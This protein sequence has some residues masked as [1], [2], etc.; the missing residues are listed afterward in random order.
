M[1]SAQTLPAVAPYQPT[2]FGDVGK[3][4]NPDGSFYVYFDTA[5]WG[6]KLDGFIEQMHQLLVAAVPDEEQKQMAE[7]V[8]QL[9]GGFVKESGLHA[10]RGVGMSSVPESDTFY[11]NRVAVVHGLPGPPEGLYWDMFVDGNAP[12]AFLDSVP[13]DAVLAIYSPFKPKA[14][15]DW[16]K[17]AVVDTGYEPVAASLNQWVMGMRGMGVDVDQW[18]ESVGPRMGLMVTV[19]RDQTALLPLP[20]GGKLEIPQMAAAV[21]FEVKDDT[22]FQFVDAMLQPMPNVIRLDDADLRIR[23]VQVPVPVPINV[24]PTIARMGPYLIL[25]S[26]DEIVKAMDACRHGEKAVLRTDEE[27]QALSKDLPTEGIGFS[28]LSRRFGGTIAAIMQG[29]LAADPN[30]Q[31]VSALMSALQ[32]QQSSYGVSLRMP[33][34]VVGISRTDFEL[35]ETLVAQ[36]AVMPVALMAGVT[37]P[38]LAKARGRAREVGDMSNLKQIG[39]GLF[40]FADDHNGQFPQDLGETWPYV[41]NGQVFVSPQGRT[42]A[43]QNAEQVRAGQCDYLYFVGGKKQVDI[44]NP[45]QTPA[46]CTKPG[47][48]PRGVNVL[49]CDGHVTRSMVVD[50]GLKALIDAAQPPQQ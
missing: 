41:G 36:A 17:Q 8:F 22:I 48:L 26:N 42:A 20:T 34:G 11:Y 7:V 9:L 21:A 18:I 44:Q 23:S 31:P 37:M 49:Y 10:V 43:P 46:A 13:Q 25:A 3:Y 24:K 19:S 50:A 33:D 40:L 47:L 30:A 12:F 45:S 15:W 4:L 16:V 38:A 35:G 1:V 5:K 39:L 2:S 28:F 14:G 29:A 27:F 32:R 6:T